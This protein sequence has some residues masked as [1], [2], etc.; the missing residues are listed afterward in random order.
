MAITVRTSPV[1][2]YITLR[3]ILHVQGKNN[4]TKSILCEVRR[5]GTGLN[6][7]MSWS[8]ALESDL[9]PLWAPYRTFSR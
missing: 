7:G 6:P 3:N 4:E 1:H 5:E 9:Y 2:W 8:Y